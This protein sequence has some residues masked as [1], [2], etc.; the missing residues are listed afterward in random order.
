ML[1]HEMPTYEKA[2]MHKRSCSICKLDEDTKNDV[3]SALLRGKTL[4]WIRKMLEEKG[5]QV[6]NES[7]AKHRT[8][9]PFLIN[10]KQLAGVVKDC[11]MISRIG[12][13][14]NEVHERAAVV[15]NARLAYD[16]AKTIC[17]LQLW[18]GTIP[19]LLGR[20]AEELEG[21]KAIPVKDLAS[22]LDLLVKNG[23]LLGGDATERLEMNGQVKHSDNSTIGMLLKTDPTA[24]DALADLYRRAARLETTGEI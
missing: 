3:N 23:A 22:S 20:L 21:N 8:Y 19:Q 18:T 2:E 5:I 24:K 11:E 15:A 1:P 7:I 17:Q 9:L 6:A 13:E 12:I 10:E 16:Y 4:T 14:P